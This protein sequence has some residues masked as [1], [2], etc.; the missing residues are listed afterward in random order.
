MEIEPE[1]SMIDVPDVV[2]EARFPVER[3]AAVDLRPSREAGPHVVPPSLHRGVELE[4]LHQERA[5]N[6]E[7]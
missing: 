2:L 3:I 5:E 6:F 1:G 7:D 4:I